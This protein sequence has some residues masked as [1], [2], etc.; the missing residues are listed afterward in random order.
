LK[1]PPERLFQ[2]I[3]YQ[4]ADRRL[5]ERALRHRSAGPDHN[6]RLEFLGD[7]LLGVVVA[8]ALYRAF[9]QADEGQLSR[10][11]AVL[12]KKEALAEVARELA[13]GDFLDLGAG[14]VRTGGQSRSS[15]LADALEAVLGAVYLDGGFDAAARVILGLLRGRIDTLDPELQGKDPKTR[16]QEYLQARRLSLPV[17]EVLDTRGEQHRQTF[18]VRCILPESDLRVEAAGSSRRKA[19]QA[20]ASEAL[21]ALNEIAGDG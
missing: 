3:D 10:L 13:L 18:R 12:V 16:L 21:R 8:E 1:Q 15:T 2:T 17:Y 4:F 20:A 6:E 7:A 14:E 19:E 11:R 5:A 9:P